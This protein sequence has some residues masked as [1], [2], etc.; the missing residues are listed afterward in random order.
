MRHFGR[1]FERNPDQAAK[2]LRM[3][4]QAIGVELTELGIDVDCA[5]CLDVPVPTA[6]DVIGD[7]ALS[8]D[9]SVVAELAV[10][11][12]DGLIDAGVVPVIKHLPG[13]GRALV[14]SHETLPVVE[15]AVEDLIETDFHPFRT[16][17]DLPVTAMTGHVV[18]TAV[19]RDRPATLSEK[20][21]KT[22]IRERIGFSGLLFSDD[23]GMKALSGSFLDRAVQCL[24]AGCDIALHCSGELSEMRQ[25]A[26]GCTELSDRAAAAAEKIDA[27][28]GNPRVEIDRT[29]VAFEV[30]T[31]LEAA[32]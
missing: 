17:A 5:P 28:R 20:M 19:D 8:E 15:V 22:L 13:H 24:D 1:L 14:D 23:L 6:H 30:A 16:V 12:C 29:A 11:A 25:V 18:F 27:Y 7:R 26:A 4:M 2:A 32:T 10:A 21:I 3:N 9:P 31:L